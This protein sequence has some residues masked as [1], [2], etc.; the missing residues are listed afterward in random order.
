MR[1]IARQYNDGSMN[2]SSSD[3]VERARQLLATSYD[4]DDV[5]LIEV[6][7]TVIRSFGKPKLEVVAPDI[8]SLARDLYNIWSGDGQLDHHM[9]LLGKAL[10]RTGGRP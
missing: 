4:D 9:R 1:C 10:D 5:E 2:V 6:E 7:V 3:D 8:E